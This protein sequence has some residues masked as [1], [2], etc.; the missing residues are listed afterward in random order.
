MLINRVKWQ[1][2]VFFMVLLPRA[3]FS[4]LAFLNFATTPK[5]YVNCQAAGAVLLL[6][7]RHYS[8]KILA[9]FVL[10]TI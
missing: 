3:F 1:R 5:N 2:C 8:K 7:M 10:F 4:F 9:A 6:E